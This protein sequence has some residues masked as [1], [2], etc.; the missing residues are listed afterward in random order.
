MEQIQAVE[1]DRKW[2]EFSLVITDH[3]G[4]IAAN[5]VSFNRDT[6]TD[7]ISFAY[8]PLPHEAGH[9]GEVIVNAELAIEEGSQRGNVAREFA[10]YIA[11]GCDHLS[12][13]DDQ[14]DEQRAAMHAR[15]FAWLDQAEAAGLLDD[16]LVTIAP[17]TA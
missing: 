10:L 5:Q 2:V 12:G 14:T 6:T 16:S 11:H 17:P 7:V 1:S 13:A 8:E 3:A 15:E 4:M 9:S